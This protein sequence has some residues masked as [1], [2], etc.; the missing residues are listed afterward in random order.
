M[1]NL[2]NKDTFIESKHNFENLFF[3]KLGELVLLKGTENINYQDYIDISFKIYTE[4]AKLHRKEMEEIKDYIDGYYDEADVKKV[5]KFI[6]NK[7][8]K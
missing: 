4:Q 1:S 7:L 2:Q 5:I 8:N 3:I 6:N